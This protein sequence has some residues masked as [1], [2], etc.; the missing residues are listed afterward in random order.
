M[1]GFDDLYKEFAEIPFGVSSAFMV[2]LHRPIGPP[3]IPVLTKV[4]RAG[5]LKLA[6][7]KRAQGEEGLV[8]TLQ[9][10]AMVDPAIQQALDYEQAVAER[11]NY[12]QQLAALSE[13]MQ[14]AEQRAQMAEQTSMQL[15]QAQADTAQQ[16]AMAQQQANSEA[17]SKQ[18]AIQQA[19]MAKDENLQSQLIAAQ[20]REQV[21]AMADQLQQQVEQFKQLAAQDPLQQIQQQQMAQQQAMAQPDP[22]QP[23]DVQ[24]EQ[25]EAINA[26]QDAAVQGQQAQN[27]QVQEA[28]KQQV[29]QAQQQGGGMVAQSAHGMGKV[30]IMRAKLAALKYVSNEPSRDQVI[31]AAGGMHAKTFNL[32]AIRKGDTARASYDHKSGLMTISNRAGGKPNAMF[33]V[34]PGSGKG[35]DPAVRFQR[36]P[37]AGNTKMASI[38]KCSKCGGMVKK[39]M[40]KCSGCGCMVKEAS[41]GRVASFTTPKIQESAADKIKAALT[42]V[43][44]E[45]QQFGDTPIEE[46]IGGKEKTA[47][48]WKGTAALTGAGALGGGAIGAVRS[49]NRLDSPSDIA[50]NAAMGAGIGGLAGLGTAGAVKGI[51]ALRSRA[52]SKAGTAAASE[53]GEVVAKAPAASQLAETFPPAPTGG[54]VDPMDNFTARGRAH[55]AWEYLNQP[56]QF[57]SPIKVGA[58]RMNERLLEVL[59]AR[60]RG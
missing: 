1:S 38:T 58:D 9:S 15:Q 28:Q 26:Q 47:L 31:N 40:T 7:I 22:T 5:L 12:E 57:Q 59:E 46:Y 13:Q 11:D 53:A 18:Q 41:V 56:V 19:I 60:R 29:Q 33:K 6:M 36:L 39:G 27:T 8:D 17:V 48:G 24:K 42:K 10:Q 16:M 44:Q 25:M 45:K 52:A 35:D 3:P 2:Q 50:R 49:A 20:N 23:A 43:V 30:D 54:G 37:N 32:D 21:V 51:G 14:Q 55:R 4:A 34:I